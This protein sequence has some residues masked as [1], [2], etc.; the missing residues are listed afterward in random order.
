MQGASM[1]RPRKAVPASITN[2]RRT[3]PY[4]ELQVFN[5]FAFMI[6]LRHPAKPTVPDRRALRER[7]HGLRDRFAA[8]SGVEASIALAA[9]LSEVLAELM[10]ERLGLY[11]PLRS[12][13]NAASACL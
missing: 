8:E 5:C 10:P 2:W 13:C 1:P 11:W 9:H 6:V 7:L 4:T 3:R 12:E